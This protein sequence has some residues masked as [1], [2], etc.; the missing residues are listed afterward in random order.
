MEWISGNYLSLVHVQSLPYHFLAR[1]S[2][3]RAVV[4]STRVFL[5]RLQVNRAAHRQLLS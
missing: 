3:A 2:G 4:M 5:A 1:T